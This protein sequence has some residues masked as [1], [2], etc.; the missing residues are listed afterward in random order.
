[1]GVSFILSK[2][3]KY[4]FQ[5]TNPVFAFSLNKESHIDPSVSISNITLSGKVIVEK[6]SVIDNSQLS[7]N[8]KVGS[9]VKITSS[10]LSGNISIG[11]GAKI[12]D[13]VIIS[14]EIEVGRNTSLNGPNTDLR[15]RLNKIKIGNFCSIARNVTF[16]EYNHDITKLTT[17]FINTN[18]L[19]TSVKKDVVSKGPIEIEHDVWIGTHCV[20][21]SGVKIGTGAV[22]AANSVVTKDIE[23]Y[24]IVGGS[25]AK[26]ISYRFDEKTREEL[27]RSKWWDRSDKE[28]LDIYNSF[29]IKK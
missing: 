21:L 19:G 5:K 6:E 7:G 24:A 10:A 29:N 15:C 26:F 12:I 16:Q 14:G 9:N 28:I 27:L 8:I 22:I 17:Y 25:P 18:L 20:I 23:P 4:L 13:G 11:N 3:K 1:M 2:V